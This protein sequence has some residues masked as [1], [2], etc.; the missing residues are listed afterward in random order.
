MG[1]RN[2]LVPFENEAGKVRRRYARLT[3]KE[4]EELSAIFPEPFIDHLR[5]HG[6]C[7]FA[8][9]L[10]WTV[11]PKHLES[12][13]AD[14][15]LDAP[16]HAFGHNA[17][18]DVYVL[19]RDRVVALYSSGGTL[20][21]SADLVDFLNDVLGPNQLRKSDVAPLKKKLGP[22][23]WDE[24]YTYAPAFPIETDDVRT[25]SRGK[26]LPY[27]SIVGQLVA[28]VKIADSLKPRQ[29][30]RLKLPSDLLD[31]VADAEKELDERKK[32][33]GY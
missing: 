9:G 1:E 7:S 33:K 3:E 10:F 25:A 12:G 20:T 6:W 8:G 23:D 5:R 11:S 15:K 30:P 28:P 27:V 16:V 2:D 4:L 26:L 13:I 29:T 22:V 18:G 24:C 19:C 31:L 21:H 17:F 32:K 14:W